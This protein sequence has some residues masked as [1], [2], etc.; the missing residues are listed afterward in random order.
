MSSANFTT[1]ITISVASIIISMLTS[2]G[3]YCVLVTTCLTYCTFLMFDTVTTTVF[4][5]INYPF[6]TMPS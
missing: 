1:N 3:D 5:I 6:K 4:F 2:S